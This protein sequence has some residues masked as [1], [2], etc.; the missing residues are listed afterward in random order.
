MAKRKN[1]PPSSSFTSKS[2]KDLMILGHT[3]NQLIRGSLCVC[4]SARSSC[5]HVEQPDERRHHQI[6]PNLHQQSQMSRVCDQGKNLLAHLLSSRCGVDV[7]SAVCV[8]CGSD[9]RPACFLFVS[10]GLLKVDVWSP[11]PRVESS[12]C[13]TGSRSTLRPFCR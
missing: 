2:V 4:A 11:E 5:G 13:G 9:V 12:L 3:Q 10:S 7:S 1:V 8:E 6:C